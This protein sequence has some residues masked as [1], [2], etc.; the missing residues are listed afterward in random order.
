[1]F[2]ALKALGEKDIRQ[3]VYLTAKASGVQ[4]VSEGLNRMAESGLKVNS[5]S[6]RSKQLTCFCSNGGCERDEEGRC[7]MTIGFFDRLP[8]AREELLAL[9]V[10]TPAAMDELALKYELCPFELA[11]QMLPWMSLVV[12]DY[13]YVFDPLVRLPWFSEPR[14]RSLVLVDEAH[15]LVDR[16]RSMFSAK[17]D[18]YMGQCV[19]DSLVKRLL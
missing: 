13:N 10:I 7:P 16:S 11:L 3:I 8:A 15:N 12:C 5:I 9:G 19:L 6:L 17:L 18:R 4:T 1:L 14:R 2:P